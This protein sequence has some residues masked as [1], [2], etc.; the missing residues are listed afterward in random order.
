M[1]PVRYSGPRRRGRTATVVLLVAVVGAMGFL[2]Y[3][4]WA[5]AETESRP[6]PPPEGAVAVPVA[7]VAIPAGCLVTGQH[8]DVIYRKPEVI[9]PELV[10]SARDLVGRVLLVDKQPGQAFTKANLAP[11]GTR[12]GLAA[13][14]P[15]GRRA[16][17]IDI[18]K[19]E[20][21]TGYLS[22]G[23]V[24]DV[25]AVRSVST[26]ASKGARHSAASQ[27]VESEVI[28]RGAIVI[29]PP[30]LRAGLNAAP[31][32]GGHSHGA[33]AEPRRVEEITLAVDPAEAAAIAEAV[34]NATI[35]FL[36]HSARPLPDG[37][38]A[39]S[40]ADGSERSPVRLVEII[41]GTDFQGQTTR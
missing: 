24:L 16:L 17:T 5:R 37:H 36:M 32:S 33:S 28:A 4:Q 26:R 30:Q 41:K 2:G 22:K 8:L 21:T 15:P 10:A 23:D 18:T 27:P 31:A 12:P 20:G 6:A 40:A 39:A 25:L 1:K 13:T 9:A 11:E 7:R 3:R 19:V 35:R 29:V 34:E 14:I 38:E